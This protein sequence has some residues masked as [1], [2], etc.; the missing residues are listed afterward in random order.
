MT[1][2]KATRIR[3]DFNGLFGDIL[4]LSHEDTRP[5]ADGNL[6]TFR[7]GMSVIA[8]DEDTDEFGNRD[9]LIACGIVER[10][11]ESLRCLGS[12]WILRIDSS[13]VRHKSEL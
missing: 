13:G 1:E 5:D 9:D 12:R 6:V 3:G 10:S 8:F 7:A 4:C 11:P 2:S